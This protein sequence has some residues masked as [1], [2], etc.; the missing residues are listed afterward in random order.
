MVASTGVSA[1][2]GSSGIAL[3][4]ALSPNVWNLLSDSSGIAGGFCLAPQLVDIMILKKKGRH[5]V[6][7]SVIRIEEA[8]K[9][10]GWS[11]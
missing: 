1:T 7:D 4:H 9:M 10:H 8:S 11:G 5:F 2:A 3:K 6:R